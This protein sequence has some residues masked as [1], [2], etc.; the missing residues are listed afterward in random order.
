[1]T[2]VGVSF[3][4]DWATGPGEVQP[5]LKIAINTNTLFVISSLFTTRKLLVSVK[6]LSTKIS[7]FQ[8]GT[9]MEKI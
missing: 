6:I 1:M 5:E 4:V 8:E 7:G 2:R 9:T 3:H